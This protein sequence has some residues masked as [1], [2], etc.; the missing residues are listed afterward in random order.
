M[1]DADTFVEIECSQWTKSGQ[2]VCGDAFISQRIPEEGRLI[3]TLADGLGSG[4]KANILAT[5][6]AS[7]SQKFSAANRDVL[8]FTPIMM[9]S[10]PICQQRHISYSTFTIF[11][12]VIDERAKIIEQGNPQCL[13]IRDNKSIPIE[14]KRISGTTDARS[15]YI[16]SFAPVVGDRVIICSDGVSRAGTGTKEYSFG[17]EMAGCFKYVQSVL[18]NEPDISARELS[19]KIRNEAIAKWPGRKTMDDISCVVIYFRKPRKTVILSGPPY[20]KSKDREYARKL[21]DK[22]HRVVV[23][24]GTTA[25]IVS[26]ELDLE[27]MVDM[28]SG[29]NSL[30]PSSIIEGADLV[31][32]GILTLTQCAHYLEDG[33][34][35]DN[36]PAG[37]LATIL[38]DSD[39]LNFIIGTRVNEAH[40]DPTLPV[41][42]EIRRN[43]IKRMTACLQE[44]Y[45]KDVRIEYI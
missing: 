26:R 40:Q 11:N 13:L 17:W 29:N 33:V 45:L 22:S 9:D 35:P 24:G 38:I 10:L 44:K 12:C 43:I 8:K 2:N 20:D 16:S 30:P 4:V 14:R 25:Q 21:L 18:E 1:Y 42:L 27:V 31:T 7:M 37:R 34:F 36:D 41:D 39:D 32:E 19:L 15:T 5:M 3:A 28:S 23:C 6:T